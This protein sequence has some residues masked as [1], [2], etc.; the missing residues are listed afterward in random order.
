MKSKKILRK[1]PKTKKYYTDIKNNKQLFDD[2]KISKL[3]I[4]TFSEFYY[5]L[6][7]RFLR[8]GKNLS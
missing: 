5:I 3:T 1:D 2:E 7:K 8:E 6:L 4:Q